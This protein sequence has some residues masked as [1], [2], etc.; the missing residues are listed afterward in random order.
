MVNDLKWNPASPT[1]VAICLSDG[2][3]SVLQVTDS[4]KVYATLPSSAAVTS[5]E[6]QPWRARRML[7]TKEQTL[8]EGFINTGCL[9]QE[10]VS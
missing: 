1:M 5:G 6:W 2:S 10:E 3:I 7:G 4:V 9:S 8:I